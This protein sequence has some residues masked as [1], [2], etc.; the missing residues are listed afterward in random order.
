M[1][2]SQLNLMNFNEPDVSQKLRGGYYTPPELTIFLTK[3]IGGN[4]PKNILEPSCGDGEFIESLVNEFGE[5][6]NITG[7]EFFSDEAEKASRRGSE[8]TKIIVSDAFA[9]YMKNK[10][11]AKFDAV[12]GN[13]PF[14]R[15]QNFPEEHRSKAFQL[16]IEDGLSPSKLTN[17]W[18]PFVVLAT[19]TLKQG[20]RLAMVLPA[21]ILQVTYARELRKYL[22]KKYEK[23]DIVTFKRLVFFGIQQEIVLILGERKDCLSSGISLL[24]FED[25]SDLQHKKLINKKKRHKILD[26][27]HDNEKWIQ[28]YLSK[29]ELDLIRYIESSKAFIRLGD[30]ASVDVGVV[31]GNNNFFIL[32]SKKA[33][34]LRLLDYC[35]P[36]IGRSNHLSG[37]SFT[38]ADYEK[39]SLTGEKILLFNPGKVSRD[40]LNKNLSDYI[41]AGESLGVTEGYKCRIRLP[42]WW[43][44]PS[45][46]NPDAFLLRQI[47]EGPKIIANQT[48]A[49]STDT[50]HR[51]RMT[52]DVSA[53]LL[54][55]S[56]FNSLTFALSEV[57][58]RSYG[59]G[60]LELEPTEAENLLIPASRPNV[61]LPFDDIDKFIRAKETSKA[62][63]IVDSTLLINSG[64]SKREIHTLR[65]IWL[66]LKTRRN[67]RNHSYKK[68]VYSSESVSVSPLAWGGKPLY[69]DA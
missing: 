29:N 3:W 34:L 38:Q 15:Y 35:S 52:S 7:V 18:L 31:T 42:N 55:V 41:Q 68:T 32:D 30:I 26:I 57:R 69:L 56:S 46:W 5:S 40:H 19:K 6:A 49:T 51:I 37:I 53:Q 59:G 62:L 16:M 43:N 23:I 21:E 63:D 13:P 1:K 22:S 60:V 14:I 65:G 24:E 2:T 61:K 4:N 36:V 17:S 58:G 33:S 8:K 11:E 45:I 44:L 27:D 28:F 39:L 25:L 12:I 47:H 10:P 9:W 20:G 50:V 54:A 48:L 64:L 66:K 67:S